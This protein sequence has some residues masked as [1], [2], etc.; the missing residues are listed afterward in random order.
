MTKAAKVGKPAINAK[1]APTICWLLQPKLAHQAFPSHKLPI[2]KPIAE[3]AN[4]F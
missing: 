2:I 3:G 4:K 1:W